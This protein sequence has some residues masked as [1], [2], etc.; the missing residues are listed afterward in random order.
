MGTYVAAKGA[1]TAFS[2]SMAVELGKYGIR[3]NVV[4]PGLIFT[5]PLYNEALRCMKKN[6]VKSY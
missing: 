5:T 4:A 3:S 1:I 6:L 2:R